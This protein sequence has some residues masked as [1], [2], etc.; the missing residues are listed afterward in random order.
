VETI[1]L[2][3]QIK[4]SVG[5]WC[6]RLTWRWRDGEPAKAF[7]PTQGDLESLCWV[8]ISTPKVSEKLKLIWD[9]TDPDRGGARG[10]SK[11]LSVLCTNTYKDEHRR[12]STDS[13]EILGVQLD[14]PTT[15]EHENVR[16]VDTLTDE[17]I[18]EVP[19][20]FIEDV[21]SELTPIEF[22][23]LVEDHIRLGLS[24]REIEKR[25][26]QGFSKSIVA[27][28]IS[29]AFKKLKA[30][31]E[32]NKKSRASYLLRLNHRTRY[33]PARIRPEIRDEWLDT[34]RSEVVPFSDCQHL[35]E[36]GGWMGQNFDIG[37]TPQPGRYALCAD[38]WQKYW[39]SLC[40]WLEQTTEEI[41]LEMATQ[42]L[43][44]PDGTNGRSESLFIGSGNENE[45]TTATEGKERE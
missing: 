10:V 44:V 29:N 31:G 6:H 22:Q 39:R 43:A 45:R 27:L 36:H 19:D 28:I 24:I 16:V 1:S 34:L 11:F 14:G 3:D 33:N 13:P 30:F 8:K 9:G 17:T 4:K 26:G 25:R 7:D 42:G 15:V 18:N 38:C 21:R 12:L 37:G 5:Y 23:V 20:F 2:E 35:I 40:E 32:R 41:A